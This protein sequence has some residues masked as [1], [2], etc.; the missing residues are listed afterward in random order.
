[1][2]NNPLTEGLL[3]REG[4]EDAE[5]GHPRCLSGLRA[6]LGWEGPE[7]TVALEGGDTSKWD[8]VIDLLNLPK[9]EQKN[10][11]KGGYEWMLAIRLPKTASTKEKE[12]EA[13][14][15]FKAKECGAKNRRV[16][17][18]LDKL[19]V[20]TDRKVAGSKQDG[21]TTE[22]IVCDETLAGTLNCVIGIFL[23]FLQT[24]SESHKAPIEILKFNSVEVNKVFIC[25]R[26]SP[27]LAQILADMGEYTVQLSEE[28]VEKIGITIK[29]RTNFVP[30]YVKFDQVHMDNGYLKSHF[31]PDKPNEQTI[32][33]HIDRIRLFYDKLT[34]YINVW[35][36]TQMLQPLNITM[37]MFPVH[38]EV[39]IQKLQQH[40]ATWKL[41]LLPSERVQPLDDIRNYYG[42][43]IAFF[44]MF[45]ETM[46]KGLV[47]MF[48]LTLMMS[49][50]FWGRHTSWALSYSTVTVAWIVGLQKYWKR[51][52]AFQANRWGSDY[53]HS[54]SSVKDPI[55]PE[56]KGTDL[57][58]EVDDNKL[59]KRV[60]PKTRLIGRMIS[61]VVEMFVILLVT[62]GVI[63]N[64]LAI[65]TGWI[66]RTSGNILVSVQIRVFSMIWNWIVPMLT[67]GEQHVTVFAAGQF[68]AL[69]MFVFLFFNSFNA[70][71]WIAY[72]SPRY[73]PQAC[74]TGG[75]D[76]RTVLTGTLVTALPVL[77]IISSVGLL[78]PFINIWR[79][80]RKQDKDLKELAAK[81]DALPA[82]AISSMEM[83]TKMLE[84]TDSDL[85]GAYMQIISP[86]AYFSMW[87]VA[88]PVVT[89]VLAYVAIS[90]SHGVDA[91]RLT[92]LYRRPFPHRVADI[93][94]RNGIMTFLKY[95]SIVNIAGLLV[96]NPHVDL[97]GMMGMLPERCHAFAYTHPTNTSVAFEVKAGVLPPQCTMT[98][99]AS[100][101]AF[102]IVVTLLCGSVALFDSYVPDVGPVTVMNRK[103]Q[104]HQREVLFDLDLQ[105]FNEEVVLSGH[106]RW[107]E[108]RYHESSP[109]LRPGDPLYVECVTVGA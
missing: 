45:T 61:I 72:M 21:E 31:R 74:F 10:I 40:W 65:S 85:A 71:F 77:V 75:G 67:A 103:R 54:F 98:N 102:F 63:A 34:D 99:V 64:R 89:C 94:I 56:F 78:V 105:T 16:Q 2:P 82:F 68:N 23:S 22:I 60:D 36:L 76:C 84:F 19:T 80:Y 90:V 46:R 41:F 62:C 32:L 58:S 48:L 87:G 83:Q 11:G 53:T 37:N 3:A 33:N 14:A 73:D 88:A 51:L 59:E 30:A 1:M 81:G 50:M 9:E 13:F 5:R 25:T 57:P 47:V 7:D 107:E 96:T 18:M 55:N 92:R 17:D 109:Q 70:F 6:A 106:S 49:L 27:K 95:S 26:M 43:E 44:F 4:P 38:D 52:E 28:G 42:E 108:S 100:L 39:Q 79:K 91:Y 24:L 12:L 101:F 20:T 86:F 69:K 35:E 8:G 66:S 97:P 15:K 93:G 104:V 29:D